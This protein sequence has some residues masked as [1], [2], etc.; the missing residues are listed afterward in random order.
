MNISINDCGYAQPLVSICIPVY[1][2]E[3]TVASTLQ[4]IIGQTYQNLEILV[5]DNASTDGTLKIIKEFEDPRIKIYRNDLNIGCEANW[6]RC[7]DLAAGEYIAIFHADDLYMPNIVEKQVLAFLE[8]KDIGAVFALATYINVRGQPRGEYR[9]PL[10]LKR[11][12]IYHFQE[13]FIATL[14]Y[15][16]IFFTPSCMVKGQ[17]YKEMRAFDYKRFST[18]ADLDMWLRI[19]EKTPV[20]I[21]HEK[22]MS[23]RL[24]QQQVHYPY[25]LSHTEEVAFFKVM[26][27]WLLYRCINLEIPPGALSSYEFMRDID[28]ITRSINYLIKGDDRAAKYLLKE[29]ATVAAFRRALQSVSRPILVFYWLFGILLLGSGPLSGYLAK[30]ARKFMRKFDSRYK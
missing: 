13:I 14:K 2:A 15:I 21:L 8:N 7:I 24:S 9:I 11:K 10:C 22:L 18:A 30:N 1:N 23:Y 27:Y 25:N 29:I 12:Q 6:N 5:V 4:S 17:I 26:D 28:K 3:K 19:S 16:N 20:A